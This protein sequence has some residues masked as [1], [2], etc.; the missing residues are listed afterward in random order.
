MRRTR[1]TRAGR[2]ERRVEGMGRD[3]RVCACE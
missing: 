3:V 1:R 2:E